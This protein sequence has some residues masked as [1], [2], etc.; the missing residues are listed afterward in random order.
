M[1]RSYCLLR[2]IS[3][4]IVIGVLGLMALVVVG[5]L[6]YGSFED[7]VLRVRAEVASY[8]P[9]P[10]Y[11]PTPLPRPAKTV[12]AVANPAMGSQAVTATPARIPAATGTAT[13]R[14][15][16]SGTAVARQASPDASFLFSDALAAGA[17]TPARPAGF[18]PQPRATLL[19]GG[20]PT[21][22]PGATPSTLVDVLTAEPP[23]AAPAA[24]P[25]YRRALPVTQLTGFTHIWQRWNNC[26]PSTLAMYLSFYGQLYDQADLANVLKG[27]KDDKNVSPEEVVAYARQLGWRA[28]VRYNGD[29]DRLHL[30]LSNGIPVMI[31]TWLEKEQPGDGVGHYRLLTGYD[32]ASQQWTVYDSYVTK[33]VRS[34]QLYAGIPMTYAELNGWWEVFNRPYVLVYPEASEPLV[35]SILGQDADDAAMWQR[36][37]AQAQSEAQQRPNDPY[38][39]FNVGTDLAALGRFDQAVMPYERARVIGLPWRMLWYQF[40]PFRAYYM[41]GDYEQL[42][43]L[44]DATIATQGEIE[45]VYYWKGMGLAGQG[46]FDGAR[47]AWQHALS[48][49]ASYAEAAA[50]L[51]RLN[52][53]SARDQPQG[54]APVGTGSAGRGI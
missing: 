42:A 7:L 22:R 13:A 35:R 21:A 32:D 15:T 16:E 19:P 40:G 2:A 29:F 28:V 10:L 3:L 27:N 8:R 44:A 31:E 34:D 20:Q 38:T 49:R 5:S 39:W 41:T 53:P 52:Q 54:L 45:E 6:R 24:S 23:P 1:G 18:T 37:L 43:A 25:L 51:T 30:F 36:A 17:P 9:H 12:Q 47:Q 26:G 11:V 50:A 48:L 4:I 14:P 46:R 33:G